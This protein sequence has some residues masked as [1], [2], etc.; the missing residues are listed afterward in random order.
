MT[1]HEALHPRVDIDKLY[2]ARKGGRKLASV[3]NCVGVAIGGLE[4]YT[5]KKGQRLIAPANNNNMN[6][7]N[8]RTTRKT[9]IKI[10]KT[11]MGRKITTWRL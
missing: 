6:I 3:E 2:V 1:M 7:N 4:E 8:L 9:T 10:W 5:K 11:K